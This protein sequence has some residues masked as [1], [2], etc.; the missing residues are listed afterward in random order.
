MLQAVP[1]AIVFIADTPH[2]PPVHQ[3]RAAMVRS[4]QDYVVL[5]GRLSPRELYRRLRS[6]GIRLEPG[7]IVRIYNLSCINLATRSLI[8]FIQ[9]LRM[10]KITLELVDLDLSFAPD[11]SEAP[12]DRFIR[13]ADEHW[14][15]MH[16]LSTQAAAKSPKGRR[17]HIQPDQLAEIEQMLRQPG[18][19]MTSVAAKLGVGRT[20]LYAFLQRNGAGPARQELPQG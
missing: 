5:G 4:D 8:Q 10:R 9:Q 12:L 17:P 6:G 18:A 3:Q 16:G 7:D 13:A 1:R 15:M 2:S 11:P 14:R 19:N 20:T